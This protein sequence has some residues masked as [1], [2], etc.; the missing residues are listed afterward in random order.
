MRKVRK[1]NATLHDITKGCYAYSRVVTPSVVL[2]DFHCLNQMM[3]LLDVGVARKVDNN[4][5]KMLRLFE[6]VVRNLQILKTVFIML[7]AKPNDLA[8]NFLLL[9]ILNKPK[10]NRVCANILW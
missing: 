10:T 6:G 4:E 2:R 8:Q 1:C 5:I 3:L 9:S 7:T